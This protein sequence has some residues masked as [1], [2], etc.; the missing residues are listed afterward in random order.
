M[1]GGLACVVEK[2]TQLLG[3][4]SVSAEQIVVKAEQHRSVSAR[5]AAA[6]KNFFDIAVFSRFLFRKGDRRCAILDK[7]GVFCVGIHAV[8][9]GHRSNSVFCKIFV[10][11]GLLFFAALFKS[12]AV[13]IN[14]QIK[15]VTVGKIEI[16]L[17][18]F[19]FS[20][21]NVRNFTHF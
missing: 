10:Y 14:H 7:I 11:P 17:L 5:R 4:N 16:K 18:T 9:D 8:V 13:E 15:A 21:S 12:A 20:V 3:G 6:R 1:N 2:S 19:C